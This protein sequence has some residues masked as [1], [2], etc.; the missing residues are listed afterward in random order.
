MIRP[1]QTKP[2][3]RNGVNQVGRRTKTWREVWSWLKPRLE[4]AGRAGCEFRSVLPHGEC[5]GPIDPCHSKKRAK[6]QGNDVYM[7]ALGCRKIHDQLDLKLSHEQMEKVVLT[8]IRKAGGPI[9]P[10]PEEGK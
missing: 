5:W 2:R 7:I 8:A 10:P 4:R 6:M 9:L 3:Q 1:T